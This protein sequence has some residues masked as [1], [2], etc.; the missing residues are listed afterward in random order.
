MVVTSQLCCC[1]LQVR[2]LKEVS[3]LIDIPPGGWL[4]HPGTKLDIHIEVAPKT[5]GILCTLLILD[6][7]GYP[8]P[9]HLT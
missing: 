3:V 7:G 8:P 5:C 2:P 1:L 4:L 6:F 9:D